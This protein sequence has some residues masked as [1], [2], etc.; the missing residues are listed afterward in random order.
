MNLPV[1]VLMNSHSL[2]SNSLDKFSFLVGLFFGHVVCTISFISQ[3]VKTHSHA[4][5]FF[6]WK[7]FDGDESCWY[8]MLLGKSLG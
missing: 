2:L 3:T 4:A 7:D 5:L 1:L 8:Y 6:G